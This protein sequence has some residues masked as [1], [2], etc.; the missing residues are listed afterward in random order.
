MPLILLLA[1]PVA[2]SGW[3]VV[4]PLLLGYYVVWLSCHQSL[5]SQVKQLATLNSDGDISWFAPKNATG[6]LKQ[7]GLVSQYVLRINWYSDQQQALLQQWVFA[8]QCQPEQF[9]ALAR[10]INQSNWPT[11]QA[12]NLK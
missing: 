6:R 11:S 9:S 7:G 2:I 8:D 10:Q 5:N 4:A 3:W 12:T 1:N